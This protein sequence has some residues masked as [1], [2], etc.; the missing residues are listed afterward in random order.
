MLDK[1]YVEVFKHHEVIEAVF[2]KIVE[3]VVAR[4]VGVVLTLEEYE[5]LLG[6]DENCSV[7][8]RL[9]FGIGK[10][11]EHVVLNLE[12]N[13][14]LLRTCSRFCLLFFFILNWLSPFLLRHDIIFYL[15]RPLLFDPYLQL[16]LWIIKD[17]PNLLDSFTFLLGNG[18]RIRCCWSRVTL[19]KHL[20]W[21]KDRI[22]VAQCF[23]PIP[24]MLIAENDL[25]KPRLFSNECDL[26][27]ALVAFH[28]LQG[29]DSFHFVRWMCNHFVLFS[30]I[31]YF[32]RALSCSGSIEAKLDVILLGF[33][34][35]ADD[36]LGSINFND[37]IVYLA[38]FDFNHFWKPNL[39]IKFVVWDCVQALYVLNFVVL[40][41]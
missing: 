32:E 19:W 12:F 5:L 10:T 25:V 23:R 20:N 36:G 22:P 4:K 2:L 26:G 8:F 37:S 6:V 39:H 17:Q 18:L 29:K 16:S 28:D 1:A 35:D 31:Q 14:L 11:M 13:R 33:E 40:A 9:F 30:F 15:R 34:H 27:H 24:R 3:E 7:C 41:C 21:C 38:G